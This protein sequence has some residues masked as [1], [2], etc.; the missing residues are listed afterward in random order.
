[1]GMKRALTFWY[2]EDSAQ[3]EK[4]DIAPVFESESALFK[5]DVLQDCLGVLTDLYRESAGEFFHFEEDEEDANDFL[6]EK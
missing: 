5:A 3:F 1:M 6:M 4:V 2:D